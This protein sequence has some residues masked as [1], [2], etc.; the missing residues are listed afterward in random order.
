MPVSK[1]PDGVLPLDGAAPLPVSVRNPS[2]ATLLRFA[3][4]AFLVAGALPTAFVKPVLLRYCFRR[5]HHGVQADAY[6]ASGSDSGPE[7]RCPSPSPKKRSKRQ[8]Y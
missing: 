8:S 4:G 6:E 5:E 2:L 3:S 7:Q 1:L